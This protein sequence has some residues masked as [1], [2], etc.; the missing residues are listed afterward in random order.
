MEEGL[1]GMGRVHVAETGDGYVGKQVT[2]GIVAVWQ[3]ATLTVYRL[4]DGKVVST[5][6]PRD[7]RWETEVATSSL[8]SALSLMRKME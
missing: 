1:F 3:G 6:A 2:A 7:V 5:T 4:P 8:L